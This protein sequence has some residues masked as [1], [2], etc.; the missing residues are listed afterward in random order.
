VF[1]PDPN[2]NPRLAQAIANA[3][4]GGM[5]KSTIDA[6]VARGQGLSSSGATLE[7][8]IFE[9]VFPPGIGVVIDF[10]TD[11]KARTMMEIRHLIKIHQGSNTPTGYLF[12]RRGRILLPKNGSMTE[13][14]I[15]E[16]SLEAG[17]LDI[18]ES[19]DNIAVY[20]E[21]VDTK[22]VA[23]ALADKLGADIKEA[24]IVWD[25]NE[26]TKVSVD[27][28]DELSNL[29]SLIDKLQDQIGFQGIYL[30][31]SQGKVDPELWSSF[32]SRISS[33]Y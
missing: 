7:N 10:Q 18:G 17:A 14:Q 1:G 3:K 30:N 8:V 29:C 12:E 32:Q 15:L 23:K 24:E 6:A 31:T 19:S 28:D 2:S 21:A 4:K 9:A 16:A 25:P 20:T 33:S 27:S 26:D 11:S 22:A 13:E 5:P